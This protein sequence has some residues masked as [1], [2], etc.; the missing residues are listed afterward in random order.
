MKNQSRLITNYMRKAISPSLNDRSNTFLSVDDPY[1]EN[2][3]N[4]SANNVNGK[5]LS[6]PSCIPN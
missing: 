2:N 3:H 6:M 1:E 5:E 4:N